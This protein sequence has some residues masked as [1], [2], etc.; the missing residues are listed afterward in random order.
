LSSPTPTPSETVQTEKVSIQGVNLNAA[1]ST[2][3]VYAQSTNNM[4]VTINSIVIKNSNGDT[5]CSLTPTGTSG[6]LNSN[7]ALAAITVTGITGVTTGTPYSV[8]LVSSK[9]GSFVSSAVI[10]G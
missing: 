5:V 9:G 3:T 6:A 7:G 4:A 1:S 2:V 10:A 8:T